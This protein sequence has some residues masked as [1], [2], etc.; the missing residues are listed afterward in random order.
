MRL[1]IIT[2]VGP[3]HA[4]PARHA[5][6]SVRLAKSNAKQFVPRQFDSMRHEIIEDQEGD[7]GRSKARNIGMDRHRDADWFFF[8]DADDFMR[9]DALDWNDFEAPA[10]FGSVSLD[11]SVLKEN[12]FPCDWRSI[13]L[14]GAYG[15]LS[16]GFFCN[17]RLARRMR[18]N[19]NMDAGEDF[20]FYMRLP[21][22]V[23]LDRALVE[24]GRKHRSAGGPR[25]Y[26]KIDWVGICNGVIA[27]AV[28]KEPAK[29]DLRGNAVLAQ[30]G[31]AHVEPREVSRAVR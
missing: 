25:G 27:E 2:P 14:R 11:G 30:A 21:G 24:I 22:F 6:E 1:A 16:M 18:F 10:T 20:E 15:T 3:G 28:A 23:K 5:Y 31:S 19:E 9:P 7:L 8:L 26:D 4:I 29:Y 17:A 12:V 13:A